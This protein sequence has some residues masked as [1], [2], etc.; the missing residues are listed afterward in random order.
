MYLSINLYNG[1]YYDYQHKIMVYQYIT[2]NFI[3]ISIIHIFLNIR[4][5][6]N[7]LLYKIEHIILELSEFNMNT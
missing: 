6:I 7:C 5:D 4:M 2:D 1:M 3:Y